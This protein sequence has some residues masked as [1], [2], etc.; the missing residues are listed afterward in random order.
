MNLSVN[1]GG[2]VI[3]NPV[4][5]ASGVF[6]YGE[7]YIK[8]GNIDWFGAVSTKGTTLTPRAGNVPP[9]TCETPSGLLNSIGLENPGAKIVIDRKLP[10]LAGFNVPVIANISA[11]SYDEFSQLAHMFEESSHVSALEVNVSCP[12][13][14]AGG[15]AFGTDPQTCYRATKAVRR[16]WNGPLIVK[17]TPN[18]KD[19]T[20]IAKA[21]VEG[22]ADVLSL[23]NTLVGMAIDIKTRKPILGKAKGGLSGPAIK[24]VALRCVWEVSQAV[25]VPII[26]IG[27]I[28]SAK[29]ALEFIMAGAS[30]VAL[31]TSLL[32][33][34]AMPKKVV[35]GIEQYGITESIESLQD[36]VGV[37]WKD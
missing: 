34:P 18:V 28:R 15:M 20:S 13:V 16:V 27:G 10:W 8:A 29:D 33:D 5:A 32:I 7:E 11:D 36:I 4:I 24:P 19:I 22:G 9:R 2:L 31:G 17:L 1:L 30:A 14:E 12:N 21:A 23:I 37:A 25:S 3:K 6:G 35:E 26:G